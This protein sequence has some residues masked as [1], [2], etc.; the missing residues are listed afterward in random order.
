MTG[1]VSKSPLVEYCEGA[2]ASLNAQ[3]AMTNVIGHAATAGSARER[4]IQDF[5]IA[6]LPE[7][8]SVVSGVIVDSKGHRS[9]QQD[10]VLMLKSMPR[11]RFASGHDLVFQE[12]TVATFEIKSKISS[13]NTIEKIGENIRS[14]RCLSPSSL[15]VARLGDTSWPHARIL[16][17]ILTYNGADLARVAE[18][19]EALPDSDKPDLY[20]DLTKGILLRKDGGCAPPDAAAGSYS[21]QVGPPIGLAHC[22]TILSRVTSAVQVRGVEWND[23]IS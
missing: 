20:L 8:T 17:A 2:I 6:H 3:Y 18:W 7:M 12:G 15:A 11:L 21:T 9:K 13:R 23:Y 14:V 19:L 5:L 22:L 16:S 4:V 10:I 1:K